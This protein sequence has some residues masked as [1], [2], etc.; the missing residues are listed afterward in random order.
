M[1]IVAGFG[2][3]LAAALIVPSSIERNHNQTQKDWY[4]EKIKDGISIAPPSIVFPIV[5]TILYIFMAA[6]IAIWAVKPEEELRSG[7]YIGTWIVIVL[8]IIFNKLWTVLFFSFRDKRWSIG[9][10]FADALLIF[11]TALVIVILFHVS[12]ESN[13][14]VFVLWYPYVLWSFFAFVL[15]TTIFEGRAELQLAGRITEFAS[16]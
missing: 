9:A 10:A 4:N 13:A 11:L 6:A 5:W 14:W 3:A 8:N 15:T 12:S 16:M 7:V 1:E 2:A